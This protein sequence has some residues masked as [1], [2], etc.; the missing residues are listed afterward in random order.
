MFRSNFRREG[1]CSKSVTK[2][3]YRN[4]VLVRE[5]I[6]KLVFHCE[7]SKLSETDCVQEI[8]LYLNVTLYT[9]HEK[10]TANET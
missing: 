6:F 2:T 9:M 4:K 7:T 1:V 3:L 8:V 5:W 10:D